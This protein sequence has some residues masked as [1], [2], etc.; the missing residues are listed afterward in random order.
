MKFKSPPTKVIVRM[1][2]WLGDAVMVTPV[3]AEIRKQWPE[4][5]ITAMCRGGVAS[6]LQADPHVDALLSFDR[7]QHDVIHK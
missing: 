6:L 2:N 5:H 7:R 4:V 3:L 1:P